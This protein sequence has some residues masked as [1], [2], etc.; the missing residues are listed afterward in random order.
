MTQHLYHTHPTSSQP[1]Q[2]S[3]NSNAALHSTH[4]YTTTS[5]KDMN[6]YYQ[7]QQQAPPPQQQQQGQQYEQ[8]DQGHYPHYV[9]PPVQPP[10][11]PRPLH[12]QN[13]QHY[14]RHQQQQQQQQYGQPQMHQPVQ[15]P[16]VYS[17]MNSALPQGQMQQSPYSQSQYPPVSSSAPSQPQ[18]NEQQAMSQQTLAPP[19]SGGPS[20]QPS[21]PA[22]DRTA[23]FSG[24]NGNY[25]YRL[26]C[27]QQ[28]QRA[29]MCG[30]GDKD[31]RPVTPPPCVR[32]IITEIGTGNEVD[33]SEIDSSFFVL[34]VDLWDEKAG[35]EVNLV[36]SSTSSPA[37]SISTAT[38]TSYPPPPERPLVDQYGTPMGYYQDPA[39]GQSFMAPLHHPNQYGQMQQMGG[40]PYGAPMNFN[41]QMYMPQQQYPMPVAQHSAAM[42][43]RNLIGSL[44]VNASKLDDTR[45]QPGFWFVLQDLSVRTEGWFRLKMNFIDVGT[46]INPSSNGGLNKGKARVLASC[47]SDKFQVFSAKKFPGVI[48]STPLSKKF[49]QQGIKIPIRRDNKN[50]NADDDDL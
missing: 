31:R 30:F 34:S 39:T 47:F 42:F 29:R 15:L 33:V 49:A 27:E 19:P 46:G 48:E 20:V 38:T 17:G 43:S 10:A 12:Q 11:D 16:P 23:P 3:G 36:R 7:Q 50:E 13:P 22:L 4:P 40:N 26:I 24:I 6:P 45:D 37:V 2:L 5:G 41:G 44:T 25:Q 9:G 32:L 18:W 35:Q 28:P 1:L 21:A 14:Q 8:S